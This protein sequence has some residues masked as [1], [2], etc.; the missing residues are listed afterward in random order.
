M[1]SDIILLLLKIKPL[2]S[3]SN[4]FPNKNKTRNPRII[5]KTKKYSSLVELDKI[6]EA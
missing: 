1:N 6:F 5:E 3:W 2:P 4:I